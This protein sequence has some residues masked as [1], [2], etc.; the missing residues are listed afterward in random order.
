MVQVNLKTVLRNMNGDPFKS[1]AK[2]KRSQEE[3]SK[4]SLEEIERVL[5]DL[6]LGE[7]LSQVLGSKTDCKDIEETAKFFKLHAKI[8]NKNLTSKGIWDASIKELED[9]VE[10]LK[11][12]KPN[13]ETR[14]N[15]S[16][17]MHGQIYSIM[18]EFLDSAKSSKSTD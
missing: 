11:T 17:M 18:E 4:L 7:G 12:F 16:V 9:I 6:T 15:L 8:S 1:S 13:A 2:D 10:C 14:M 5:P 3:L